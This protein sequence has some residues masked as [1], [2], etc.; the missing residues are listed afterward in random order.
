MAPGTLIHHQARAI[1]SQLKI[2]R[3]VTAAALS[4]E[5]PRTAAERNH[6]FGIR[7]Q[8]LTKD[9]RLNRTKRFLS[10]FDDELCR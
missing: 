10:F 2:F 9:S 5:D 4:I 8:Q 7:L 3:E 6:A 1:E